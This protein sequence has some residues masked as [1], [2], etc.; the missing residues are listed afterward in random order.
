MGIIEIRT[1]SGSTVPEKRKYQS[2]LFKK[3][4]CVDSEN[5]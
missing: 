4:V 1:K 5:F 2:L 3:K